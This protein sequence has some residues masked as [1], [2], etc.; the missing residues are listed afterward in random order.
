VTFQNRKPGVG[1]RK[2]LSAKWLE[3]LVNSA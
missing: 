2:A 1:G 3:Q